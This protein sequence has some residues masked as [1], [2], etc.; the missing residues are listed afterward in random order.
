MVVGGDIDVLATAFSSKE[1][2]G[3]GQVEPVVFTTTFEKG[4][5]FNLVLGAFD[6]TMKASPEF[7][8]LLQRG[9]EWAATG[10]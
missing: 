9:S 5:C 10:T 8:T 3:S 2:N 7:K 4:R 1:H 6:Y